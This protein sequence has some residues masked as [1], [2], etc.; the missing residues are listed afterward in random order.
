VGDYPKP[1]LHLL[2]KLNDAVQSAQLVSEHFSHSFVFSLSPVEG[3]HWQ[4]KVELDSILLNP[5]RHVIH[6]EKLSEQLSQ[7]TALQGEHD[8]FLLASIPNLDK[9]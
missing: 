8:E 4:V 3:E 5:G 9:H 7:P 2:Q 1:R 6:F